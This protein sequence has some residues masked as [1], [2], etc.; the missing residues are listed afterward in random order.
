M[1]KCGFNK[2]TKHIFRTPFPKNTSGGMLL[3]QLFKKNTRKYL[4]RMEN[5]PEMV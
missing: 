2:V 4:N 1:P 3:A 5:W